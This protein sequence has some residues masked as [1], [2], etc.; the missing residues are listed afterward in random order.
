LIGSNGQI[1][2]DP[3]EHS[4]PFPCETVIKGPSH[5]SIKL[6]F[7]EKFD[8]PCI[9]QGGEYQSGD[10]VQIIDYSRLGYSIFTQY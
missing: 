1:I 9:K 3:L 4:K 6:E 8:V 2:Y 10:Y 7:V 5:H